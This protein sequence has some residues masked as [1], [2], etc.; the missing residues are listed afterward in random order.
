MD[1]RILGSLQVCD[2]DR[3]I[4]LSGRKQRALLA[5]LLVH[6]N[7]S[8][9]EDVL[10]DGLWGETASTKAAENLHVLVSRLRRAL[11]GK[12]IVR[13]GGGYLVRVEDGE[14]DLDLFERLRREQRF[15]DALAL[16]RGPPLADFAYEGWAENEIRRLDEMRVLVLEERIEADLESGKHA[17][18]VGELQ[19]LVAEHPLRET[20]RRHLIVALY[21]S[22]RQAEA[23]GAY[24]DAR[25]M[26]D[27]ELGL[28]PTPAL[29]ELEGAVLRQ[30]P[31]LDPPSR[32]RSI[33]PRGRRRRGALAVAVA[34]MFG[35]AGA[36]S[37]VVLLQRDEGDRRASAATLQDRPTTTSSSRVRETPTTTPRVVAVRDRRT[38]PKPKASPPR[39]V[40]E[41]TTQAA[42]PPAQ[43]LPAPP[44]PAATSTAGKP[45]VRARTTTTQKPPPPPPA[46][47]RIE[48]DFNDGVINRTIWQR[49]ATSGVTVEEVNGRLEIAIASTAVAGGD[50]NIISGTLGTTCRYQGDFD[51]RV[52]F[53]L[54]EWPSGSGVNTNLASWYNAYS[55]TIGRF[56]SNLGRE[57]YAGWFPGTANSIA[58]EHPTGTLRI[59]REGSQTVAQ[60]RSSGKWQSLVSARVS[61]APLIG[62][63]IYSRDDW[64]ADKPV[65]VAFDNFVML[66][67]QPVC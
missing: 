20:L 13:D 48:D 2:G 67:D 21:R 28:E 19:T 24:R 42:P 31:E 12:R 32:V 10:I 3:E 30:D 46:Q 58:A 26:L 53:E 7:R 52:D 36:A 6:A 14:L 49:S 62:L 29:R 1:F 51:V 17:E 33:V 37:A 66:V 41:T 15:E 4:A 38:R 59:V 60:Y 5:L 35:F 44:P 64:F 18:L 9:P 54:L 65:R 63:S 16:W 55:A 47:T 22:G 57:E 8:V 50:Y 39:A 61:G 45:A 43:P 25:R 56:S 23:L 34:A 40:T 27:E 11:G